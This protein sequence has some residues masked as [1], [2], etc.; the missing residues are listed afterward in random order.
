MHV[1]ANKETTANKWLSKN[2]EDKKQARYPRLYCP[3][4]LQIQFS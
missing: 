4:T 2:L 3:K 1:S